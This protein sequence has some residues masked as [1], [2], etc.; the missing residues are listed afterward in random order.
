MNLINS[1][2]HRVPPEFF[3]L[4]DKVLGYIGQ[5]RPSC[6]NGTILRRYAVTSNP[7]GMPSQVVLHMDQCPTCQS[8]MKGIL[9]RYH[10]NKP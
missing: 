7:E 1:I 9:V 2:K 6:P 10:N 8:N 5:S 4:R 3:K